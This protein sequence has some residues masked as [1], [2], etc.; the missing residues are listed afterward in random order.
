MSFRA[1]A[2]CVLPQRTIDVFPGLYARIR[3][4]VE[5]LE[6][7]RDVNSLVRAYRRLALGRC[8]RRPHRH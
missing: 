3:S 7:I 6:A 4:T 2:N 5:C 8:H 1:A